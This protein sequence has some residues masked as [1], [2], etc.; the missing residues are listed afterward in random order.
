MWVQDEMSYDKFHSQAE[1]LYRVEQDQKYSGRL[2]HVN[3]T[4]WPCAPVWKEEIPEVLAATR[5]GRVGGQSY[6]YGDVV[7]IEQNVQAVDPDFFTMFDFPLSHGNVSSVMED[8]NSIVLDEETA[9]KYF[10]SEDPIGKVLTANDQYTLTVTGVIADP[11]TNSGFQPK[12]LVSIDFAKKTGNYVDNW[13]S[14]NIVTFILIQEKANLVE[15]NR[16]LTEVVGNNRDEESKTK[17]MAAPLTDIHLYSYFGFSNSGDMIILVYVFSIIAGFILLIA[18]IN[19]MNLATARSANRAREIGI[20]KV[21]GAKRK[22]LIYQF[23]SES[24]VL[25]FLAVV[26]ALVFVNL[27]L[28]IFN[29]ITFKE[30]NAGYILQGKFILGLVLITIITGIISGSYPALFLSAFQPV[31]VLKGQLSIGASQILRK[32]LVIFQFTLSIVLI[33]GTI[34][35]YQQLNYMRT[36][37]L[38]F[39]YKNV[40]AVGIRGSIGENYEAIRSELSQLPQVLGITASSHRP[41]N[42]GSNSSG[43]NWD[44]KDPE[45]ELIV[46]QS[47]VDFDYVETMKIKMVEG[48]AFSREFPSDVTDDEHI[49][50]IINETFEKIIDKESIVNENLQFLGAEGP[51]IGVM[52]DFHFLSVQNEIEPLAIILYPEWFN[53]MLVRLSP[54]DITQSLAAVEEGWNM[55]LPNYPFEYRFLDEDFDMMYR[56]EMGVSELIKYF[57]ILIIIIASLGL[58]GLASYT[59]EQRKKEFGVRKVLGATVTNLVLLMINQFIKWVLFACAIAFPIAYFVLNKYLEN[60]A[61]RIDLEAGTFLLAG[62]LALVIA[63]LTVSYQSIKAALTNPAQILKYE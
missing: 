14:N 23:I 31:K 17:F 61:Y 12:M 28:P 36:K 6:R 54:G 26:V 44:G 63:I 50:F 41:T 21:V 40:I 60:Y 56:T 45:M 11:P 27:L 25:S 37:E 59:A 42:I 57:T 2:Y 34:V 58:F 47:S 4:P 32:I 9:K 49:T 35:I 38:G 13:G 43:A 10:G 46:R 15:V 39:D 62:L 33:I 7:F 55:V 5:L 52:K 20:R 3:V 24:T 1:N 22:N 53:T 30:F 29:Q 19:F 18:C 16:K 51:I 8:P 48:R